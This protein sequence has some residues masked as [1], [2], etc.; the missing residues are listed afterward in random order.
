[1]AQLRAHTCAQLRTNE[2]NRMHAAF[3]PILESRMD[4]V[5]CG[6]ATSLRFR[7]SPVK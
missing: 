2:R 5:A 1:M 7:F 6:H 4:D 3:S